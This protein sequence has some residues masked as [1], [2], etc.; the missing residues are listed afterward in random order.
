MQ[1]YKDFTKFEKKYKKYGI[2]N[3]MCNNK[4]LYLVKKI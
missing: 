2:E 3:K 4:G 1:A